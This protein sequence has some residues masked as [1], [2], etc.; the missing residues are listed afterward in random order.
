MAV[1]IR[2]GRPLP[3]HLQRKGKTFQKDFG[4]LFQPK[5]GEVITSSPE[6]TNDDKLS[7]H[8]RWDIVQK[9]K[10]GFGRRWKIDYLSNLQNRTK[11]KSP[12][13]NFKVGEIVIIKVGNIP[14]ATWL[15][16]P[17]PEQESVWFHF[18]RLRA[19]R[20]GIDWAGK[21]GTIQWQVLP[22]SVQ[23][24]NDQVGGWADGSCL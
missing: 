3:E 23:V 17:S 11:W 5:L 6:H 24:A 16:D 20:K 9:M 4:F 10:S 22:L 2:L 14:P 15:L 13:N 21:V 18:K 7:L 1:E 8:S 19:G 12:N